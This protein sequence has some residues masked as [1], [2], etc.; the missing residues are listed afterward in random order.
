MQMSKYLHLRA[1]WSGLDQEFITGQLKEK[2]ELGG[3]AGVRPSVSVKG[4]VAGRGR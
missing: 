2:R 1:A 4:R 3:A